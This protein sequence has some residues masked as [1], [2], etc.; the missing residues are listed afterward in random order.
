MVYSCTDTMAFEIMIK[1]TFLVPGAAQPE[2]IF[3]DTNCQARKQ[4][5]KDPWFAD[6]GMCIDIWHFLNKHAQSDEYCQVF[7][8]ASGYPVLQSRTSQTPGLIHVQTY[9]IRYILVVVVHV[10]LS[11]IYRSYPRLCPS[12]GPL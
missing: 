10:S 1:N 5:E 11:R 12:L 4:A 8:N 7:C 3:Y 9:P 2:H 6:I